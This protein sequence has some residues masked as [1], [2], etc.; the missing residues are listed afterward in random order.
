M[1]GKFYPPSFPAGLKEEKIV[2]AHGAGGM[3]MHRLIKNIFLKYFGNKVLER[4]E[5]AAVLSLNGK[6]LCFTTD[7]YVVKPLFFSGGDIGKL[8]I[9]GTV[10]D[11]AVLGAEP[12]YISLA[13]VLRE[14]VKLA[15]LEKICASVARTAK[16]AGV[17]IVTGD[18][19]VIEAGEEEIY[20]N[21][22]GIGIRRQV[23]L[24]VEFVRAGDRIV[25]NG[26]LGEH[27]AAIALARGDYR[28]RA[29][30]KSDCAP[31]NRL[32][33]AVLDCGGIKLMRDPT[34]GGLATTLN[35]FADRSGLGFVIEEESLP[36]PE[37]VRGV[38]DLLGLDPLYMANEGKVV[39]VCARETVEKI[40]KAMRRYPEG[41]KARVI[42]EVVK[43]P[44][45]V[46]LRTRL[47]S[48][49]RLLMLEGEQLPRIC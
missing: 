7:S 31:L 10:N 46:W 44:A 18:T 27:E 40:L 33:A 20:I 22:S 37:G 45:G 9:S 16:R 47:G 8:A 14:G 42:G 41:R 17:E 26:G 32:I 12:K 43:E 25:I 11:L 4:L 1:K 39:V 30:L 28:L 19:K 29:R 5:D 48:L 3:K 21:T 23:R 24:G 38:A 15:T 36:V 49:R 13:F 2:L 6:N 35:E 34:R